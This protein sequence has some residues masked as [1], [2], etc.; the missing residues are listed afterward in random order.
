MGVGVMGPSFDAGSGAMPQ[1]YGHGFMGS[2]ALALT[3]ALTVERASARR[4]LR[5]RKGSGRAFGE[6]LLQL[7]VRHAGGRSGGSAASALRECECDAREA[8]ELAKEFSTDD[9]GA[10]VH[11]VLGRVARGGDTAA[12]KV[13]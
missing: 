9:S 1:H 7:V 10:F 8:V 3:T 4:A 11:G 13:H 6:Q 5:V 12:E 2:R